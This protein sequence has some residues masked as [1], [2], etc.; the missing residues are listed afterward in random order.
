MKNSES[1]KPIKTSRTILDLLNASRK[2]SNEHSNSNDFENQSISID[3]VEE[4]QNEIVS[5]Q[6]NCININN[7]R[8]YTLPRYFKFGLNREIRS[9]C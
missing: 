5:N 2:A 3:L 9:S 6:F 4:Y 1:G 8:L 7:C